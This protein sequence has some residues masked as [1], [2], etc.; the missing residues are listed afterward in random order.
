[1]ATSPAGSSTTQLGEVWPDVNVKL[2]ALLRARGEIADADDIVQEVAVRVLQSGVTFTDA[3]DLYPWAAAVARNLH[4]SRLR[5]RARIVGVDSIPTQQ[6]ADDVAESAHWRH[7]WTAALTHLTEMSAEDR[8]VLL[9]PLLE[10]DPANS[11]PE[12]GRVSVRRHRAR[13]SL[14]GRLR[15]LLGALLPLGGAWRLIRRQGTAVIG[16]ATLSAALII[17]AG[18]GAWNAQP[19]PTQNPLRNGLGRI[20]AVVTTSPA[21][22][23][24][25]HTATPPAPGPTRAVLAN[26]DR[27]LT[28]QPGSAPGVRVD[29][30]HAGGPRPIACLH[31]PL[32]EGLCTPPVPNTKATA[33][34]STLTAEL[35]R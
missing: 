8:R 27:H 26:N 10:R 2:R 3:A 21:I 7:V 18:S 33:P 24:R 14:R 34:G 29:E 35:G 12:P 15:G 19:R 1:M 17:T 25:V 30:T 5:E 4:V 22:P 13:A 20:D 32:V 6:A 16:S 11:T 28:L 23:G 31:G 9:D